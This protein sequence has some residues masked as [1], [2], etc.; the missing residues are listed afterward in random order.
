MLISLF[1][2]PTSNTSLAVQSVLVLAEVVFDSYCVLPAGTSEELKTAWATKKTD[3]IILYSDCPDRNIID[4]YLKNNF[5]LLVFLERHDR[6]ARFIQRSR[7]LS[8]ENATRTSSLMLSSL[9]DLAISRNAAAVQC[10]FPSTPLRF[11]LSSV[12]EF[13]GIPASGIAIDEAVRRSNQRFDFNAPGNDLA[14]DEFGGQD[15]LCGVLSNFDNLLTKKPICNMRWVKEL[16]LTADP[17]GEPLQHPVNLVGGGRVLFYG[18]YLHAPAGRW[19]ATP[20][21]S[22]SQNYSGNRLLIEVSSQEVLASGY[23]E[24]ADDGIFN[25]SIEFEVKEARNPIEIRFTLAKGAIEGFFDLEYV[26]IYRVQ[27]PSNP[28]GD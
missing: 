1:G 25:C 16:F 22:V 2:N 27:V 13:F 12:V 26:D 11:F 14:S 28:V 10:N 15:H 6:V 7:S 4:L 8:P 20:V 18:P 5:P 23:L 24:I 3:Q 17:L 9:H 19:I 21:F